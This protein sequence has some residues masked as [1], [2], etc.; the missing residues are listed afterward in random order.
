MLPSIP[1]ISGGGLTIGNTSQALPPAATAA[2]E[3]SH[4]MSPAPTGGSVPASPT[5]SIAGGEIPWSDARIMPWGSEAH[6][7]N[8]EYID[9]AIHVRRTIE[10]LR[11]STESES[12]SESE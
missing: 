5:Y 2:L 1:G 12:E 6:E 3:Y 10:A 9:K 4:W 11:V 7:E 8:G